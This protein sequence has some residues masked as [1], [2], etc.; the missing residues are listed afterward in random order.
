VTPAALAVAF[1]VF[2]V[3]QHQKF[4]EMAENNHR[5]RLPLPAPRGVLF[6]RH[7]K[8]LVENQNTFNIALDRE[9]SGNIDDTLRLVAA[10]TGADEAKMRETVNRRRE[11]SYRPIVLIENA[12]IEQATPSARCQE[13]RASSSRKC[14]RASIPRARWGRTSSATSARRARPISRGRST[15]EPNPARWWACRAVA[16]R[17]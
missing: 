9:Q 2:Q 3:A 15:M 12:T 1:W 8:V 17:P 5:R 7:G 10:A 4:D 14:Q 13:L 6:D 11:P 16:Y